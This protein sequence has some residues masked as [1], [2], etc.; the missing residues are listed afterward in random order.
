MLAFR[1][2]LRNWRSG[3]LKLLSA[4]LMLAVAVLSGISVFTNRLDTSM[5]LQRSAMLGADLQIES[6]SANPP[7][8]AVQAGAAG[9]QHSQSVSFESMLYAG[10]EMAL[11]SVKAVSAGY[12]L[13]GEAEISD[14][15]F[16]TGSRDVSVA[17]G[18]PAPG[19]VWLDSRLVASLH[20]RPGD[21]VQ[22]GERQ[23]RFSKVLI[24][25][26]DQF[27]LNPRLLMNDADLASTG[28][29]QPG[30]R[31]SYRFLLASDDTQRLNAMLTQ[32][33]SQLTP[34]QEV[35]RPEQMLER[36]RRIADNGKQF[37]LL[38][39]IIAVLL[40][41][42]AIAIAA[43]QFAERHSSQVA[44][45]KCLGVSAARIRQLYVVQLLLL[46]VM[47]TLAGLACGQLIQELVAQS[48]QQVV[49]FKLSAP[50]ISPYVLSFSGGI[51]CV[52]FFALP[53]MWFLPAV[54][55]LKILR[56]EL[57]LQTA[58]LWMQALSGLIAILLLI[59]LFSA[60]LRLTAIFSGGLSA[61][62]LVAMLLTYL[63]MALSRLLMM[64]LQGSWRLAFANIYRRQAESLMQM[65][66]FS[67]AIM[68]L[69]VLTIVRSSVM[70]EW[71][72]SI[73]AGAANHFLLNI[74]PDEVSD[75]KAMLDQQQIRY[76]PFYPSLRA[77]IAQINGKTPDAA[78][79]KKSRTLQ[80]E[81]DVSWTA[82]L[83]EGD[84]IT[85]GK[86]WGQWQRSAAN[87][88]GVSVGAES[89]KNM[90]L[91]LGDRLRFSV[92]GY[93]LEAEVASFRKITPSATRNS[94]AFLFEPQA[95]QSY[96]ASYSTGFYLPAAQKSFVL[97]LLHKYPN[98]LLLELDRMFSQMK[99]TIQQVTDAVL[100]V[101]CLS[102]AAGALVLLSV[103]SASTGRRR[104][105]NGLL[106]ALGSPAAL[107]AGSIFKEFAV[108][109]AL[110]GSVAVI[111]GEL[112]LAAIQTLVLQLPVQAH[113][114]YWLLT[115]L[116]SAVLLATLGS[117]ACRQ[118]ITTPPSVILRGASAS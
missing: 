71:R 4:A 88:P 79:R 66:V 55:P 89:A 12:P 60:D 104:Q 68:A 83:M 75:L 10:E 62:I 76:Q 63:L 85:E 57:K 53:A 114:L 13:R 77:R 41:G 69:L 6:P 47:A 49:R 20:L 86:W 67:I 72:A 24:R 87:L 39:T 2:L 38:S 96:T 58:Q 34:G 99:T 9:V 101:L 112:I 7:E 105:E 74:A 42:V 102:V 45:M 17:R 73:P 108:L 82:D 110:A 109:G 1:L 54:S 59:A 26:P 5:R 95:M 11:A 43:R 65:L 78:F 81:N 46:S 48:L 84:Q 3:E 14:L 94:F 32:L 44:M 36:I 80:I 61:L 90:G 15:P 27:S 40:A 92:E 31:L 37:L 100:L 117:I 91:R 16:A 115:P 64:R 107:I 118:V 103:V 21:P 25:E 8:W 35:M 22:V 51:L 97:P 29:V 70:E 33:S 28:V 113:Y 19:E 56:R 106:R 52:M 116:G 18:I 30:A 50:A 23:L 93:E 111:A 98:L